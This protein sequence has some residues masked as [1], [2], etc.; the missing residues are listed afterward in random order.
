MK[1]KKIYS[2]NLLFALLISLVIF[3][4]GNANEVIGADIF[5]ETNYQDKNIV[6][7]E[8]AAENITKIAVTDTDSDIQQNKKI[9]QNEK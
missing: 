3:L 2:R 9:N 7:P 8:I 4:T 5:T 6:N 1:M